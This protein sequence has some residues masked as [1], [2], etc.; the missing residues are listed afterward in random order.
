MLNISKK[1]QPQ[2][3][4]VEEQNKIVSAIQQAE[5]CTSGEIRLYVENH[6]PFHYANA[7]DRSEE[8][9]AKL[10]MQRTQQHNAVLLYVALKD[11]LLAVFA[12]NGIYCAVGEKFWDERVQTMIKHFN[13]ENYVEGIVQVIAEIGNALSQFFPYNAQTDV[14]E[15]PDDIV[16]GR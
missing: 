14:N 11:R 12:D 16:F 3:F 1:K 9:F 6:C 5:T 15:L 7:L 4:S 2:F 13:R 10:Q 8:V